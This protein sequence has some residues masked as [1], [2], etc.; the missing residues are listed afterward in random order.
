MIYLF[1]GRFKNDRRYNMQGSYRPM[2]NQ[3]LKTIK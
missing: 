1:L 3:T 2:E